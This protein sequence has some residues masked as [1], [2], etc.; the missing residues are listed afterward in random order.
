MADEAVMR[1]IELRLG[2]LYIY[3]MLWDGSG[4]RARSQA[5]WA[6]FCRHFKLSE[7]SDSF[8]GL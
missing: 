8:P 3:G 2:D 7:F 5:L 1:V 4:V 6:M